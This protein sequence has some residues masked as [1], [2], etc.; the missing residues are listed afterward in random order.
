MKKLIFF[1]LIGTGLTACKNDTKA[2]DS[3]AEY[4][5]VY[6][7]IVANKDV[8]L[9]PFM[10]AYRLHLYQAG[11]ATQALKNELFPTATITEGTDGQ[12]VTLI[13]TEPSS[14]PIDDFSRSGE[15][16]VRTGGTPLT[17]EGA[18]WQVTANNAEAI[19][20]ILYPG[21][22]Y[23]QLGIDA[24]DYTV[25]NAGENRFRVQA[26]AIYMSSFYLQSLWNWSLDMIVTRTQGAGSDLSGSRF[27][28]EAGD[29]PSAGGGLNTISGLRY[30]Y[31]ILEPLLYATDCG[32]L[33]R[34]GGIERIILTD[35]KDYT[36]RD[37]LV[38]D[39]GLT[40]NSCAPAFSLSVRTADDKNWTTHH[41]TPNGE[42][43]D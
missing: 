16:T 6:D 15:V 34:S 19:Y 23:W 35:M 39:F 2:G 4:F 40:Y 11:G 41:Y 38:A 1:L 29:A 27:E 17:D 36:G 9:D 14:Q 22:D 28:M 24:G 21:K 18:V 32:F 7:G 31:E 8:A 13:F 26:D 25:S 33:V 12:T 10:I 20:N 3:L 30:R 37:S 42:L 5:P 43:I